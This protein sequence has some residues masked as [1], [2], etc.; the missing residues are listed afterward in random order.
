MAI[1]SNLVLTKITKNFTQTLLLCGGHYLPTFESGE[2]GG[3]GGATPSNS[4]PLHQFDQ[5]KYI[6]LKVSF[7]KITLYRWIKSSYNTSLPA[8]SINSTC[9]LL[10]IFD[11][12]KHKLHHKIFL[13]PTLR[14]LTWPTKFSDSRGGGI[15]WAVHHFKVSSTS[16]LQSFMFLWG[17]RIQLLP[18]SPVKSMRQTGLVFAGLNP[19]PTSNFYV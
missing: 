19:L 10:N 14:Q 5:L 18:H 12:N 16:R 6:S 11:C 17:H 7:V 13:P 2:W 4:P 1:L 9:P 8:P 3:G 15:G